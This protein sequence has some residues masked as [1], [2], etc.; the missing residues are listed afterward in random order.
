LSDH[1]VAQFR[2]LELEI[3]RLGKENQSERSAPA[4]PPPEALA[5][6]QAAQ[7]RAAELQEQCDEQKQAATAAE[8][9]RRR[10]QREVERLEQEAAGLPDRAEL[11]TQLNAARSDASR[12]KRE[13]DQIKKQ[14]IPPP[15]DS[16]EIQSLRRQMEELRGVVAKLPENFRTNPSVIGAKMERL[17]ELEKENTSLKTKCDALFQE[18]YRLKQT[19]AAR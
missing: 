7:R 18:N 4:A 16:A 9:E 2:Q 19:K 8:R 17:K 6:L 15:Q 14:P 5:E 10:L 11:E 1:F 3:A 12:L 13:L